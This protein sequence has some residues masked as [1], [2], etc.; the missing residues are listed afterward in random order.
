MCESATETS[1]VRGTTIWRV[2]LPEQPSMR[3]FLQNS[4]QKL[5]ITCRMCSTDV[6]L[7]C[8]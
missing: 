3:V 8:P 1:L 4:L 5:L 2:F 6:Q 7:W